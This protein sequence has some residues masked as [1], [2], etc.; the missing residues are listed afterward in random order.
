MDAVIGLIIA[1][2]WGFNYIAIKMS[3][4]HF[5]PIFATGLRFALVAAILIW[6]TKPPKGMFLQII[7]IS[8]VF[9]TAHFAFLFVGMTKVDL[10][11]SAI[12]LQLGTAFSAIFSWILLKDS[13][14]WKRTLGMAISFGGIMIVVGTPSAASS[15]FFIALCFISAICWGVTNIQ[16][17]MLDRIGPFQLNAWMS[18]FAAPQLFLLSLLVEQGQWAAVQSAEFKEWASVFYMAVGASIGAYGMWYYLMNKYEV[19]SIVGINLLPPV[20]AAVASTL[21]LGEIMTWEKIV[22]GLIT[23]I[24]VAV[25][26]IRWNRTVGSIK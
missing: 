13:F 18:L 1:H 5:P 14:G 17:K 12:I 25:I 15:L 8:V 7:A 22:G 23:L 19:S 9:G 4:L 3:I 26:Q 10:S 20:I 21:L 2:L 16:I 11:V 24:G 6:F